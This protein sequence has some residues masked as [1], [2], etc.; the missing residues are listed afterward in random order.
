MRE[1]YEKIREEIKEIEDFIKRK[2]TDSEDLM[3]ED[4]D[5]VAMLMRCRRLLKYSDDFTNAYIDAMEAQ[6]E[7]LDKILSKLN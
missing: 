5:M 2:I 6:T 4:P 3:Y 1:S 7:K